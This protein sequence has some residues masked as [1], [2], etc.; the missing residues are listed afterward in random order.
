MI[1]MTS[2]LDVLLYELYLYLNFLYL[3]PILYVI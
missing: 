2:L 3:Y 1:K